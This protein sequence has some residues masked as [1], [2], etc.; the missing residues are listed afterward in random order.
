GLRAGGVVLGVLGAA[1]IGTGVGL[2]LKTQS[3]S[4]N[5]AKN[6]PSQQ[7]EDERKKLETWGWVSYGVGAAA[8]A[9]GIVMYI[10]GWP[11]DDSA[12]LALLPSVTSAGGNVLLQGK[13]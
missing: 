13:F 3:I 8:L 1:A 6:G 12:K 5:E 2:A 4:S 11:N 10:V 9:A 7:Q